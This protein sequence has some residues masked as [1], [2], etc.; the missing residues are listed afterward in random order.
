MKRKA[1]VLTF[2]DG[3]DYIHE[4]L[5]EVNQRY[6]KRLVQALEATGEVQAVSQTKLTNTPHAYYHIIRKDVCLA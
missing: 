1:G 5:L 4:D 6:Q 3:R 2:S